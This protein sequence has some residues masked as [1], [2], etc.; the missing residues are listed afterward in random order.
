MS[1]E[2][3]IAIGTLAAGVVGLGRM[4]WSNWGKNTPVSRDNS[5]PHTASGDASN[6]T[7]F[8]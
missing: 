4:L 5:T 1:I 8:S 6:Q 3:W 2:T 7:P